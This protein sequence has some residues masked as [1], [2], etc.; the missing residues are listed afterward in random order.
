MTTLTQT[1][2]PTSDR[3]RDR[4]AMADRIMLAITV[5][6]M[7]LALYTVY[8]WGIELAAMRLVLDGAALGALTAIFVVP[9][10]L[11]LTLTRGYRRLGGAGLICASYLMGLGL[12]C[13]SLYAG[14]HLAGPAATLGGVACAGFGV[15]P[16]AIVGALVHA[17]W[18]MAAVLAGCAI[19]ALAVR[20]FGC[21][22]VR[23]AARPD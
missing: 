5:Y 13:F 17:E 20:R 8:E 1:M 11:G 22:V 10:L 4:V 19:L 2:A 18:L 15:V 16:V 9:I 6:S 23:S 21:A 3:F 12:W 7:G 14:W